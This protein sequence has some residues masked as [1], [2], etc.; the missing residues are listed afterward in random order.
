MDF[1][2][3]ISLRGPYFRKYHPNAHWIFRGHAKD[4]YALV[5][6]AL[7][8]EARPRM[9][10][11]YGRSG[12]EAKDMQLL[13]DQIYVEGALLLDFLREAD[14]E[15]L[16][17]PGDVNGFQSRLFRVFDSL[18][19]NSAMSRPGEEFVVNWPSH[20]LVPL[21]ALAQHYGLPTRLLD[22]TYSPYVAAYFA[23]LD[24]ARLPDSGSLLAVWAFEV[25]ASVQ[26]RRSTNSTE[27]PGVVSAPH[28]SNPNLHAQS[29]VFTAQSVGSMKAGEVTTSTPVDQIIRQ[30]SSSPHIS[31][32]PV[33]FHFTVPA[34]EAKK[35][36]WLLAKEGVT[37]ARLFPGY[38]GIIRSLEEES[39]WQ[40]PY[41]T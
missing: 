36:L 2:D 20:D 1:V 27:I 9:L 31:P 39:L 22:W 21:M 40:N 33:M 7:R 35:I 14:K 23:A 16:P 28:A 3:S 5:P 12:R 4:S 29:G 18:D 38:G 24:A 15:G 8:P 6:T 25:F 30:L 26:L 10:R 19:R 37:T 32:A 34:C 17:L 41:T 11:M 13:A